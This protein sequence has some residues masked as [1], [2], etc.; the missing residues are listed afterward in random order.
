[1]RTTVAFY[2]VFIRHVSGFKCTIQHEFSYE[3]GHT[4]PDDSIRPV[5]I[6]HAS[7]QSLPTNRGERLLEFF[8]TGPVVRRSPRLVILRLL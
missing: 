3:S 8:L 5:L 7:S 2:T 1:M 6:F 4:P